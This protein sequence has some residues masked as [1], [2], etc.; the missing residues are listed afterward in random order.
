MLSKSIYTFSIYKI[1]C[2][3]YIRDRAPKHL[4][5]A[6]PSPWFLMDTIAPWQQVLPALSP[7]L[8]TLS[9][10]LTVATQKHNLEVHCFSSHLGYVTVRAFV[11]IPIK[12]L[13]ILASF[14][15]YHSFFLLFLPPV[16]FL[17]LP[18]SVHLH[19]PRSLDTP[20]SLPFFSSQFIPL[21]CSPS[22]P[23]RL[24]LCQWNR[25]PR[26][27][28]RSPWTPQARWPSRWC[29]GHTHP[30]AGCTPPHGPSQNAPGFP[31]TLPVPHWTF[32]RRTAVVCCRLEDRWR[33]QGNNLVA[34]GAPRTYRTQARQSAVCRLTM[35]QSTK[36]QSR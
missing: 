26:L 15:A 22:S 32:P 2:F 30:K 20:S 11:H 25:P 24:W 3:W 8:R 7:I 16:T 34:L 5:A 10:Q 6:A 12:T 35:P 1:T 19:I 17:H 9:L 23:P 28:K 36:L 4:T 13:K 21:A 14:Q 31:P 18:N 27:W 33:L 29:L